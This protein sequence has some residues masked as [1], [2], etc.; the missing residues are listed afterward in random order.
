[1]KRK[2]KAPGKRPAQVCSVVGL[3]RLGANDTTADADAVGDDEIEALA[4]LVSKDCADFGPE[5]FLVAAL[6]RLAHYIR[7]VGWFAAHGLFSFVD[8]LHDRSRCKPLSASSKAGMSKARSGI[9]GIL[10]RE[11]RSEHATRFRETTF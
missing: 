9:A 6:L 10:L 3:L 4:V 5:A 2:G 1:M 7:P 11:E 8:R